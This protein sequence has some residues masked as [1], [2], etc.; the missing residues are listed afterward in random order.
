MPDRTNVFITV[1]TEAWPRDPDWRRTAMR[2]DIGVDI[3]GETPEGGFGIDYQMDVLDAHDLKAVFF[4]EALSA[5]V[6]GPEPLRRVVER[7]QGRGHEVQLHV[8]SEW[9]Q[10][11]DPSILPGRTGQNMKDFTEDEQAVLIARGVENLRACGARDLC[12]FRA[13]NYGANHDTLRALVR[14]GLRF[15]TSHNGYYLGAECGLQTPEPLFQPRPIEG[16]VEF[17]ISVF[18]DWPGHLRHAQLCACSARELEGALMAAWR[19]GWYAFVLVSHSFELIRGRR[20][21][22]PPPA[23][24]RIVVRRFL[25]L[26]RFL[27]EH[28]D[29]FKARGFDGL[30]PDRVPE[31]AASCPLPSSVRRTA[32]RFVEQLVR[33]V[34]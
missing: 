23:P 20:A 24:D 32:G 6:L 28:R 21:S 7:V 30:D 25:R 27:D 18:R 13:G 22:G 11:M 17:P 16:V 12:A 19:R 3:D 2:R 9:L 29:K 15:D 26:C 14:N 1:D 4:V 33:R 8:H 31:V 10:W 5:C 34:R